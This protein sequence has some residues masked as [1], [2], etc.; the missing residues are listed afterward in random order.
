M[1][2]FVTTRW[3]EINPLTYP[4]FLTSLAYSVGFLLGKGSTSSL[5]QN[6]V[7]VN[8]AIPEL[9]AIVLLGVVLAAAVTLVVEQEWLGKLASTVG[10]LA[11]LF[12]CFMFFLEGNFII[13]FA[14]GL[15]NLFF[16]VY[17]YFRV[18]EYRHERPSRSDHPVQNGPWL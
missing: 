14:I 13:F 3:R 10:F 5:Y 9:W 1:G 17:Y 11:W 18:R 8:G 16:W 6:M 2:L 12:A 7:E 15:A 4:F